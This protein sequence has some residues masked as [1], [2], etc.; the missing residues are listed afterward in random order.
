MDGD[1]FD[2]LTKGLRS[3][4]SRRRLLGG[5]GAVAA[6]LLTGR[7]ASSK[8]RPVNNGNGCSQPGRICTADETTGPSGTC[9]GNQ[10]LTC[11]TALASLCTNDT[12]NT[13]CCAPQGTACHGHCECCAPSP[14]CIDGVCA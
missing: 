4:A 13:K 10:K 9:C 8:A 2:R 12:G 3:G 6:G 11:T 1:Q 7:T 5:L 14:G